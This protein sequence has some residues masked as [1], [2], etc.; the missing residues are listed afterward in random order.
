MDATSLDWGISDELTPL[1]TLMWR[2][3]TDRAM[4]SAVMAVELL[5]CQPDWNRL[6]D[7]HEWA[8]RMVPRL[9]DRVFEPFGFA[10]APMWVRDQDF[11]LRYHLRR[12]RLGGDGSWAELLTTAAQ[13]AMTPF[14]R[15]RPPWEAVLV[16]GLPEGGSVPAEIASRADRQPHVLPDSRTGTFRRRARERTGGLP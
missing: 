2:A 7:A 1:E 4:R 9:C 12:C 11:D 3:D 16:E 10:G 8:T 6:L 5:D 14:D 15:T 13:L